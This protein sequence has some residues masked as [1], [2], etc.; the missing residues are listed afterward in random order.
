[1]MTRNNKIKTIIKNR[2]K[3]RQ[4]LNIFKQIKLISYNIYCF[5]V[6]TKSI[7]GFVFEFVTP[8]FL[9]FSTVFKLNWI[10][11]ITQY[12]YFCTL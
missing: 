8:H 4:Q 10:V 1:M 2:N 5:F 11:F 3:Y 7:I 12:F 6:K 9:R